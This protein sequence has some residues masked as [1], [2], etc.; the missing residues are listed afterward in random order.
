[1]NRLLR[2]PLLH[3]VLLGTAFFAAAAWLPGG[4]A[5]RQRIVV[6]SGQIEHLSENFR[7]AWLREPTREELDG[8]IRDYLREEVAYR[9][10][11]ALGLDRDDTV[12][13]RRLR[14]KMEFIS[15]DGAEAEPTDE[16]LAGYLE[17]NADRFRVE[18]R[19]S[20]SHVY[21][22]PERRGAALDEDVARALEQLRGGDGNWRDAGDGTLLQKEV[23][24]M[25]PS[26]IARSFGAEFATELARLSI[27]EW[28]GPIRSAY[29]VHVVIVRERIPSVVPPLEEVRDAVRRDWANDRRVAASQK[30]YA[31]L[32]KRYD[33]TVE[34]PPAAGTPGSGATR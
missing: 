10:A 2:E 9:E 27:G 29:G 16:E 6:T 23:R 15:E 24:K 12:I 7:R 1:M 13:R 32:L 31:R 34:R 18:E 3:F 22:N 11:L 14:Q 26:V 33:V 21:F 20:F 8:L 25:A 19:V 28:R 17:K 30:L 4:G 5:G